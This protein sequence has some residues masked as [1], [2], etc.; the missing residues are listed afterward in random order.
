MSLVYT[1]LVVPEKLDISRFVDLTSSNPAKLLN[2]YPTKGCLQIDSDADI[3]IWDPMRSMTLSS[4]TTTAFKVGKGSE[5]FGV[6]EFVLL[7]GTVVVADS[8]LRSINRLGTYLA[9]PAHSAAQRETGRPA[10]QR[11]DRPGCLNQ[12]VKKKPWDKKKCVSQGEI[13]AKEMGIH[14]RPLSAHGV[15]NQNDSTF[16]TFY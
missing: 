3:V 7:G 15:R 2:L 10:V 8:Q 11:V 6:P 5:V 1:E 4:T 14:Q 16:S 12:K 9:P 13:F